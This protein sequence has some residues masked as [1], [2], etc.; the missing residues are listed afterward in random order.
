MISE[1]RER[2]ASWVSGKRASGPPMDFQPPGFRDFGPGIANQP[3]HDVL[4]RES[5]GIADTATRAIATRV[6]TLN[7]E[8]K[9]KRR[10]RD[11][12]VVDEILDDHP[13]KMVLDR[14]HPNITRS[15]LLRLT[16]QWIVTV[17]EAYWLK[18]GSMLG[19]PLELHPI[20][21][22][23]IVPLVTNGVVERYR[24]RNGAG[25]EEFLPAD[26]VIRFFFPDPENM[27]ASEGYLAPEAVTADG[28][29]FAGQHLR[30]RYEKD[31]TP[32]SVLETGVDATAFSKTERDRFAAEW[33]KNYNTR[34][35]K[36]T[37]SPAI[38]PVGYKLIE[39]MMQSGADVVPLLEFWRDEQLMGYSV[40][41]SILGQVVSGDR[42]SAE[43]NQYVFD[44]HAVKPVANL[45]A[46]ALTLQL[47]PDFDSGIFVQFEE[48]VSDDKEF[49]LKQEASDLLGMVRSVNQVRQD[50]GLDPID[51]GELPVANMGQ[52]PYDIDGFDDF[53]G[54]QPGALGDLEPVDLDPED[55]GDGRSGGDPYTYYPFNTHQARTSR[56]RAEHFSP[57]NEWKRQIKRE[58][59]FVPIMLRAI[60]TIFRAQLESVLRLL[61]DQR[62]R[63]VDPEL[64]IDPDEWARLFEIRAEPIRQAA[65]IEILRETLTGLGGGDDAFAFTPEMQKVLRR[66]GADLVTNVNATTKKRLGAMLADATGK[67]ESVDQ[68]AK[69][70]K[71]EFKKRVRTDARTIARTEILKASQTA[72]LEA[73]EVMDVDQKRWNTNLDADV[74]DSHQFAEGQVRDVG[75]PFDLGNEAADAPGVGAGGGALS[76]GN[77]IN[78]RCFLTPVND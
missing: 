28:L 43:T 18:V 49:T 41:R 38:L 3:S 40:P 9:L 1:A 70:I 15:Q 19:T 45:I 24:V 44:R 22:T 4:L 58:K 52:Q 48:F 37:D 42:S 31:A 51:W 27:W 17:G 10:E 50:R 11:G 60:R 7:P 73:F 12:T 21:P 13:L 78:C 67:G 55:E 23:N 20:P 32:K 56:S 30:R 36:N 61:E 5:L 25:S 47:A 66:Q 54:D 8:V 35:G 69:R 76:A 53:P 75:Q 26:Q 74:R 29:K 71:T 57:E 68:I 39:M 6:S 77:S 65:F 33:S 14:P 2:I 16:G 59:Q 62:T 46:D 63:A 34:F 72:Q 64:L